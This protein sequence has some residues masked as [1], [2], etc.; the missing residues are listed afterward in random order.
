MMQLP[1]IPKEECTWAQEQALARY[2]LAKIKAMLAVKKN[3][4][5]L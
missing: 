5:R 4:P 3:A 1:L 2:W